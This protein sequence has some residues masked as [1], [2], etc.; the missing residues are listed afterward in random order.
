MMRNTPTCLSFING[1][2][3]KKCPFCFVVKLV[4]AGKNRDNHLRP[5]NHVHGLMK[6]FMDS[7]LNISEGL[8]FRVE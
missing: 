5:I 7:N 4:K 8:I 1:L 2:A 3:P 6:S